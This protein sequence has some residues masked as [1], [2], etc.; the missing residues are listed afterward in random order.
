MFFIYA[1]GKALYAP[2]LAREGYGV[3][4]PKITVELNKA[5]SLEYILPPDN[6]MYDNVKKLKS[7]ITVNQDNDEIF[8]GRILHDDKDLYR[9]KQVYCE[10]ELAFLLDSVQRPYSFQG[11]IQKLFRK[12]VVAHNDQV[13]TEKQFEIGDITVTAPNSITCENDKYNNTLDEIKEKL[14]GEYGGYLRTRLS[15]GKRYIDYVSEHGVVNTQVIEFGK[16]LLDIDEYITAED[17]FTVLIPLGAEIKDADGNSTGKLTI[18]SVNGKDYIEDVEGIAHFG[19]IWK[20]QEWNDVTDASELLKNGEEYL[21]SGVE[22]AVT[23]TIK[24]VDLHLLNVD[25]ERI[26][27]GDYVRVVSMPH[28]LDKYFLCIKIVY[29]LVNP[30]KTEYTFGVTFTTM[31]EKQILNTKIA[32]MTA[33]TVEK[34]A[35]LAKNSANQANQA[36][37]KVEEVIAKMPTEYVRTEMFE[38]YKQE[39]NSKLSVVYRYK[40]SVANYDALPTTNQEIGD[41]YNLLDTGANYS[42]KGDGWDKLSETIDLSLYV[43]KAEYEALLERVIELEGS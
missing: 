42:W 27:L 12:F 30:D 29:D 18:D 15:N 17:V 24:A 13:E 28:K 11:S 9:K 38:A 4:S 21:K 7:M 8:R 36:A 43:T 14:V 34:S 33:A 41:T 16:N 37:G 40:G 25:T 26:R 22:M 6:V 23:L 10:G 1:D 20:V 19:K 2:Y 31:T 35:T 3:L 5:G 39:V 32:Q